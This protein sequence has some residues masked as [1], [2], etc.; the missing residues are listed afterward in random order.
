MPFFRDVIQPATVG[1]RLA[2]AG[3]LVRGRDMKVTVALDDMNND[4]SWRL[5]DFPNMLYVIDKSGKI[6]FKAKWTR[7]ERLDKVLSKLTADQSAR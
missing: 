2:N 7:A 1:Q 3:R 4:L 6:V 5:G